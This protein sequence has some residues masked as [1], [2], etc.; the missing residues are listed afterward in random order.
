MI[1]FK[2]LYRTLLAKEILECLEIWTEYE[3]FKE[4]FKAANQNVDIIAT[5]SGSLP[6]ISIDARY[7]NQ[8]LL[9]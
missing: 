1:I 6:N 4:V 2:N 9:A 8:T 5:D 3:E 7:K